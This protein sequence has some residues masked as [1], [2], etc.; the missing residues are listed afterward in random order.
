M[1]TD[2]YKV[3]NIEREK[4]SDIDSNVDTLAGLILEIKGDIPSE[5]DEIEYNGYLFQILVA[6]NRRIGKIKLQ[7][8]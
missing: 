8:S 5:G 4:F 7:I 1:L 3:K 6:D 2:F